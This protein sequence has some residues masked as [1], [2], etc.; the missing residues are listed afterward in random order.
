MC[1]AC[2]QISIYNGSTTAMNFFLIRMRRSESQSFLIL[3]PGFI[4]TG[5]RHQLIWKTRDGK[6]NCLPARRVY[7]RTRCQ[8]H[9]TKLTGG[10]YHHHKTNSTTDAIWAWL[11][12]PHC[13]SGLLISPTSLNNPFNPSLTFFNK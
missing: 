5:T 9:H 4:S 1:L 10:Q 2:L 6:G 11:K 3:S 8:L 12:R 7:M 13:R